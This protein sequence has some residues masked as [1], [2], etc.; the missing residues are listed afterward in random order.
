VLTRPLARSRSYGQAATVASN[1]T[2]NGRVK[3]RRVEVW[4]R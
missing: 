2:E 3:N 4:L 1:E